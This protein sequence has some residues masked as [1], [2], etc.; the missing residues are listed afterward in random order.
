MPRY[1]L[2]IDGGQSST[3]ALLA[4]ESGTVLAS[5]QSGPCNHVKSAEGKTKFLSA[6]GGCLQ[7][8]FE[9]SGLRPGL[10]FASVCLGFSGGGEDKEAYVREIIH[11]ARYKVT[12]D[13]E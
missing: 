4:D 3:T 8:V 12:H 9:R 11:S 7:Q 6:I 1:Y 2:G 13:A 5:G 10:T